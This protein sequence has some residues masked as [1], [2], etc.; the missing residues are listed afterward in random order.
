MGS[1]SF[2]VFARR[3]AFPTGLKESVQQNAYG[4][5]KVLEQA[6]GSW[7]DAETAMDDLADQDRYENGHMNPDNVGG[8]HGLVHIATVDDDDAA[9]ALAGR[10]MEEGD[11]R[12]QDKRGPAG[13]ITVRQ[14]DNAFLFFGFVA[15]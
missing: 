2:T 13:C 10:L 4:N 8:K 12:I 9:M 11:T 14:G 15:T 6:Y 7:P 3:D 5:T 1:A